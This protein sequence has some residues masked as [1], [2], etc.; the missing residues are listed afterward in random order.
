MELPGNFNLKGKVAIVTGGGGL[1]GTEHCGA[2]M[3]VGAIVYI[4]DTNLPAAKEAA[5]KLNE[6][7]L[8]G[9]A[10]GLE[11]DVTSEKSV[12]GRL[13][14]IID[15]NGRIDILVNN[16]AVNPKVEEGK[17]DS[18][19]RLETFPIKQWGMQ[20]NVGLTGAFI[21]CKIFGAK[22]ADLGGGVIVNVASDLSVI[23]PD[24]RL[25]EKS[26][27]NRKQQPVKPITYSVIKSGLLGLTKYLATYWNEEGVRVN[28]LS[29]GGVYDGQSTQ[30]VEKLRDRIPLS[31]MATKQEY[32][33][34]IQFLC[35][36]AS[37]YMTGQNLII[38]GGRSVW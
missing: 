13:V 37:S 5:A 21:C 17:I 6:L 12:A 9:T 19:S 10:T 36:D 4:A 35:S 15:R 18:S 11:L 16:A 2:L 31:R 7:G 20:L 23:A 33:S 14:D 8:S 28:A 3:E 29:P 32:R 34:A 1:L 22:M 38:D 26:Y 25:Y 30:F 24:Q 27:L